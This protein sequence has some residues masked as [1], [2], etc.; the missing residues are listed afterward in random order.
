MAGIFVEA[1]Q[2]AVLEDLSVVEV[3][4]TKGCKRSDSC[5]VGNIVA[6]RPG[7]VDVGWMTMV[8]HR[9]PRVQ[10]MQSSHKMFKVMLDNS[11]LC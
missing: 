4:Y 7:K 11:L 3:G 2:E 1:R 9:D 10:R 5:H 8:G 6:V